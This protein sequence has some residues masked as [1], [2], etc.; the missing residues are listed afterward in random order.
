MKDKK[1]A[2]MTDSRSLGGK[3]IVILAK[4]EKLGREASE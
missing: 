2:Y 4:I 3:I 1:I